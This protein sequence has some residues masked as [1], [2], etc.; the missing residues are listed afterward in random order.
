[1]RPGAA[2]FL[3]PGDLDAPTGGYGYDRR[4]IAGLRQAGWTVRVLHPPGDWPFPDPSARAATRAL[5]AALPDGAV[6]LADGLAY[7]AMAAEAGAE[8]ARLRFV[9]L[10]HHPL[11][12]EAGLDPAARATL[13]ATERAALDAARAVVCTSPA[14]ARRLTDAFGVAPVRLTV[15]CPGT[16]RAPRAA[17][18]GQPPR[19]LSVGS[20]IPR[21]RHDVLIDAL[22][23]LADRPWTARIAGSAAL[24]PACA[25]ALRQRINAAG[26]AGRIVLCG[27]VVDTRAELA[28]A[29]IFALASEYEGY[30]M[31]FAEA[32]AQGVPVVACRA[33][34][35]AELVP[36]AAGGLA[37]PGDAAAFAAA[38]ALLL[39]DPARRRAAADAAFDAGRRLPTWDDTARAVAACLDGVAAGGCTP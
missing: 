14:T 26:L 7:G 16:D 36:A 11:G 4:L 37:E 35:I 29:E 13:L 38:L 15:A 6:V 10:V 19:V 5:L 12:D 27:S 39:D 1:M 3:V 20:L 30:G 32:L 24:D 22:A 25:A 9:A 34:A 33:G 21:K 23:R 28:E 8:A 18:T 2:C 31:A 17:G